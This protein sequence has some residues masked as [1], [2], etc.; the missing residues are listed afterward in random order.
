M[1]LCRAACST[2]MLTCRVGEAAS[3]GAARRVPIPFEP[4]RSCD[5]HP[6][7]T[8]R[9][10]PTYVT[11]DG[12]LFVPPQV[13]GVRKRKVSSP[14]AGVLVFRRMAMAPGTWRR[15]YFHVVMLLILSMLSVMD[16]GSDGCASERLLANDDC[17]NVDDCT[18]WCSA[19]CGA[20]GTPIAHGMIKMKSVCS[21]GSLS[22]F[23]ERV[24]RSL[25]VQA[26]S[27]VSKKSIQFKDS[28]SSSIQTTNNV[29]YLSATKQ[30]FK[31]ILKNHNLQ[32]R[33]RYSGLIQ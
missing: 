26:K 16:H 25:R 22:M 29:Y 2:T 30:S 21:I 24:S 4:F 28:S 17:R 7:S 14:P 33:V 5:L 32:P 8:C 11:A 9:S 31:K 20:A 3:L 6:L 27:N 12:P 1:Q 15:Q 19:R 13:A 23:D 10:F 18:A